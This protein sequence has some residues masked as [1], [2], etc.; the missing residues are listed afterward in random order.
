[1]G[2]LGL[3]NK[4]GVQI[5]NSSGL[6][7]G[8]SVPKASIPTAVPLPRPPQAMGRPPEDLPKFPVSP[9]FQ[10]RKPLF[11]AGPSNLPRLESEQA[12]RDFVA[13]GRKPFAPAFDDIELF[14]DKPTTLDRLE[15]NFRPTRPLY[16]GE[17]KSIDRPSAFDLHDKVRR[18]LFIRTDQFKD[19]KENML[20][21]KES[22]EEVD[23][24]NYRL[25][26]IKD[27]QD[28]QLNLFHDKIEE[29]QRKL[30]FVDKTI[31][32]KGD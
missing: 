23:E 3:F 29:I 17:I 5:K 2:F 31:F 20:G 25:N 30:I 6:G 22:L 19:V 24:I 15:S 21:V 27:D 14:D 11:N 8:L 12:V 18:P 32:E 10:E 1:M 9:G 7:A 13:P 4:K 16:K 26:N 28:S